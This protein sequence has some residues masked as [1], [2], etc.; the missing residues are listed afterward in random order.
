MGEMETKCCVCG[1]IIGDDTGCL[2]RIDSEKDISSPEYICL[3]CSDKEWNRED[4]NDDWSQTEK[5]VTYKRDLKK[6]GRNELCPCNSGK[7]YKKCCGK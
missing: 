2:Q 6:I 4:D 3:E 7:K 1:K 5:N